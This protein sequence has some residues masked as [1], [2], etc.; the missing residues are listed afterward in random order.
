[1]T[2]YE[3]INK[4]QSI[5]RQMNSVK[6]EYDRKYMFQSSSFFQQYMSQH[7]YPLLDQMEPLWDIISES[8]CESLQVENIWTGEG[9]TIELPMWMY[10]FNNWLNLSR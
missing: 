9:G 1:M 4:L 6:K 7:L 3:A 10:F 2:E 8:K 5:I